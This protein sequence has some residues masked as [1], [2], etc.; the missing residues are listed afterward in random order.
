MILGAALFLGPWQPEASLWAQTSVHSRHAQGTES[1][2][3]PVGK[4]M[5]SKK[6]GVRL[7]ELAGNSQLPHVGGLQVDFEAESVVYTFESLE[8]GSLVSP[9]QDGWARDNQYTSSQNARVVR[10]GTNTYVRGDS[11]IGIGVFRKNNSAFSIPSVDASHALTSYADILA[12]DTDAGI[13]AIFHLAHDVNADGGLQAN[14]FGPGFGMFKNMIQSSRPLSFIIR[15]AA[16]GPLTYFPAAGLAS[17]GE[18]VRLRFIQD[19][20]RGMG[21]LAYLN[22]SR[23]ETEYTVILAGV[24]LDMA[25]LSP[26]AAPSAWDAMMLRIDSIGNFAPGTFAMGVDNLVPN[27]DEHP[28]GTAFRA[29]PH[30][31]LALDLI[32]GMHYR[33]RQRSAVQDAGSTVHTFRPHRDTHQCF[34]FPQAGVERSFYSLETDAFLPQ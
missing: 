21:A 2:G 12:R 1:L 7:K 20:T 24:H 23:G 18:W 22:L 10:L 11:E 27:S 4:G 32:P 14:E 13:N 28:F 33:V 15:A 16:G 17:D 25:A 31:L 30:A 34:L 26:S 3:E 5:V 8:P 29:A 19:F 6:E 9:A